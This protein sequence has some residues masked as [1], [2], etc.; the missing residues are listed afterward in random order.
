MVSDDG[1][2]SNLSYSVLKFQKD[3]EIFEN[4]C[5]RISLVLDHMEKDE[6]GIIYVN[7]VTGSVTLTERFQKYFPGS[8][9]GYY[10]SNRPLILL[11]RLPG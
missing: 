1:V 10:N 3:E 8:V 9:F 11:S 7:S 5:S 4:M 2:R 6:R